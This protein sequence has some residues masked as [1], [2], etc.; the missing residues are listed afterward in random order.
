M[1]APHPLSRRLYYATLLGLRHIRNRLIA[2][3]GGKTVGARMLVVRAG[4]VCLIRHTYGDTTA[5]MLPGGAV[6]WRETPEEAAVRET[7]EEAGIATLTD[8]RTLWSYRHTLAGGDDIVVVCAAAT[9]EDC[10]A[11]SPEIAEAIW[12]DPDALP[13]TATERTRIAIALAGVSRG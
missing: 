1:S 2:F 7:W 13:E 10:H 6:D 9:Q 11:N 4:Q 8:V 5:W 3:L 12:A